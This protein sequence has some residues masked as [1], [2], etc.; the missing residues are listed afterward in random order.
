MSV[1]LRFTVVAGVLSDH[2]LLEILLCQR[3]TMMSAYTLL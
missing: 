2:D 3:E 1:Q